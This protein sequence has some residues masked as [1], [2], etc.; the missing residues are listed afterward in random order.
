MRDALA[1]EAVLGLLPASARRGYERYLQADELAARAHQVWR[2]R[3]LRLLG[4]VAPRPPP[5]TLLAKLRRRLQEP[6]GGG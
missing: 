2:R 4:A 1:L 5:P 6:A 3:A